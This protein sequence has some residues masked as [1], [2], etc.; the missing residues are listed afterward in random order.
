MKRRI[1]TTLRI[2]SCLE[3]PRPPKPAPAALS[4]RIRFVEV[5]EPPDEESVII[6]EPQNLG[7]G[8]WN[9]REGVMSCRSAM[10]AKNCGRN[11]RKREGFLSK[12]RGTLGAHPKTCTFRQHPTLGGNIV[13]IKKIEG[14][15]S[16][17][18]LPLHRHAPAKPGR[19]SSCA[20]GCQCPRHLR[21]PDTGWPAQTPPLSWPPGGSPGPPP[22]AGTRKTPSPLEP[23][24]ISADQLFGE[25]VRHPGGRCLGEW[26]EGKGVRLRLTAPVAL[27]PNVRQAR[28]E[29]ILCCYG[30][31]W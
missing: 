20:E 5:D 30:R 9:N 7:S 19:S 22:R 1:R 4:R 21:R 25:T 6:C 8:H 27:F 26:S 13:R 11:T 14:R 29:D 10:Y 17:T 18:L 12:A 31:G 23:E 16:P 24:P 2:A 3:L 15:C 28:E